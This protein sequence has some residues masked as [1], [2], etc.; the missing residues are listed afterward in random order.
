MIS[1][2]RPLSLA[3]DKMKKALFQPFDISKW[4]R[5][6]FTAWL[7]G[8]TD[9]N[10]S[11]GGGGNNT[12]YSTNN[13]DEFFNFPETAWNWLS[14]HPVWFSLIIAGAVFLFI[15]S[16]VL[17]WVS[18]RGKFMF[19]HNVVH[20]KADISQPWQDYR[21]QGNSLFVW[22]FL[23]GWV[24]FLSVIFVLVRS[25]LIAKALYLDDLGGIEI[26][27]SLLPYFLLLAVFLIFIGYISLFL[28]DFVVPLM[29]H[30]K[31]GVL[32]GWGE[33]I[34]LL[35][36]Q[37]FTFLVY[38][39]FVF[40]LGIAIAIGVILFALLTC[41]IGLILIAIPFIGAVVLLPVSYWLRAFSIE[42]LKQFGDQYNIFPPV[43]EVNLSDYSV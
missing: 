17:T 15:L 12:K 29:Y 10:G 31:M 20:D 6:G 3:W 35:K 11:G 8:L 23:F 42:F 43:E 22:Q 13:L 1:C 25:F 37:V 36:A 39:L 16:I 30:R 27:L 14:E 24:V 34:R 40:V 18:S 38:G 5:V 41:C 32:N 2:S 21:N 28:N 4:F 9:C 26:I 19:L 33:F 7:A